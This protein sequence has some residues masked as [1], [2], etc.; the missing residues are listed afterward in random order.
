[1]DLAEE[2]PIRGITAHMMLADHAQVAEGKLNVL[3]AGWTVTGPMPTPFAI[4]IQM[5][6]P[7]HE[8][9]R[10]HHLRLE[11]I[12]MDGVPF[13]VPTPVGPQPLALEATFPVPRP[14][15]LPSDLPASTVVAINSGPVPFPPDSYFEWRLMIDGKADADWRR[16]FRTRPMAQSDSA[17]EDAE[18][19]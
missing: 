17:S 19:A 16:A 18:A 4:T 3:G 7:W 9:G 2:D 8:T 13:T 6:F 10:D 15:G 12:D 1:M 11:V 5:E 14:E